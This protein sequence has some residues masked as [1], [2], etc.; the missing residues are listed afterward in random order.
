M[1]HIL[2]RLPFNTETIVFGLLVIYLAFY[3][4]FG[5]NFGIINVSYFLSLIFLSVSVALI[6]GFAGILSFGQTAFFGLAAYSY[7]VYT[8][9]NPGGWHTWIGALIA[10]VAA[11]LLAAL[12]G[13]IMF[14]GGV[15][16]VF[17]GLTMLA[18]TLVMATFMGQTAGPEWAIGTARLNGFNG[19]FVNS[20]SWPSGDWFTS[21]QVLHFFLIILVIVY[22]ILKLLTS[23]RWGYGLI[24]LRENRSRT[25][26]FGYNVQMMQVQVFTIAGAIAGLSGVLY[27]SWG[28][29]IDP[30]SM[31]M[32]AAITPVIYVAI[33]GRKSLT[34]AI[35][36]SLALMKLI[37]EL[38]STAPEYAMVITGAVALLAVLFVP[39]GIVYTIFKWC[40]D[41]LFKRWFLKS[42]A[43]SSESRS[44]ASQGGENV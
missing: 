39:E 10:I 31:G 1:T 19:M 13:Y 27:A 25:E 20:I 33:G 38:S 11:A 40:D 30:S 24:A 12:L 26:T 22:I 16:D 37:Q 3:P 32:T 42:D 9:N 18:V 41:T 4:S 34:A 6:W 21:K 15:N 29:Y 17:V 36:A 5:S 35:V 7:A 2:R 43:A 14:Y 23:S 28:G 44:A 8:T